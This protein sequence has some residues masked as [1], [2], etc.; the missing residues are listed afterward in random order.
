LIGKDVVDPD[1]PQN[2]VGRLRVTDPQSLRDPRPDN[3]LDSAFGYNPVGGLF[4]NI[5]GSVGDVTV[6]IKNT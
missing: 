5:A 2:F 1:H 6:I 3:S 4:T